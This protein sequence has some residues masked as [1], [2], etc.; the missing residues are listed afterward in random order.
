MNRIRGIIVAALVIAMAGLSVSA[1]AQQRVYRATDQQVRQLIRR[2][3]TRTDT[4]RTRIDANL[5][6]SRIDG[7][8]QEDNI[9]QLVANFEAAT[10]RLRDNFN[11]RRSETADVQ[12]VLDQAALID[13]FM[14]RNRLGAAAE[15]EWA[16]LRLDLNELARLYGVSWRWETSRYPRNNYPTN[17]Y[18]NNNYPANNYPQTGNWLTGTYRLDATRSDDARSIADRATRT[19]PYRNRQRTLD[20]LTARLESPT[21]LAIDRRGRSVTI[22]SSRGAQFAFEADGVERVESSPGGRTVRVRSTLSGEE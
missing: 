3:E 7:T 5:D 21:A 12:S 17:N 22:A 13:R 4:F 1:Q 20:A 11:S 18:P 14:R 15:T 8:R 10:D 2:I 6:R 19:L 16:S 9:N